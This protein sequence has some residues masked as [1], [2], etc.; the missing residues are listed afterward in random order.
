MLTSSIRRFALCALVAMAALSAAAGSSPQSPFDGTWKTDLSKTKFSPKPLI[1]YMSGGWY[2][3]VSCSPAADVP[4]DG[5]DHAVFGQPYDSISVTIVDARMIAVAGKKGLDATFEQTRT[6]SPDGNTLTF[7]STGH[8]MGGG[9]PVTFKTTA[10]RSGK[11]PTGVHATSGN[12]I[13]EKQVGSSNAL[14]TTYKTNGDEIS[15]TSPTG[16]SYTAKF[17]GKDYPVR[18]SYGCDAVSLRKVNSNAIEETDKRDGTV[19]D[20]R[21]MTVSPNGKMM[22]AVDTSKLTGRVSTCVATKQ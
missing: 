13:I 21:T 18:G 9:L 2:H 19:T 20:V 6:V 15:M 14:L 8:P 7:K 10:T 12:W 22:I 17:D 11:L 3:C 16:V 5:K 4:A 1:F